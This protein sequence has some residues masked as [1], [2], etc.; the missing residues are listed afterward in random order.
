MEVIL[1]NVSRNGNQIQLNIGFSVLINALKTQGISPRLIDLIPVD[2]DKRDEYLRSQIS[3]EKAIYGFGIIIGNDHIN[4]TEEAAKII[5]KKNPD[6]IIVYGGAL[7]TSAPKVI[8]ENCICD[9]IVA[10]EG[11]YTFPAL[12]RFLDEGGRY[13]E[14]IPGLYYI[15]DGKFHG[16][17]HKKIMSLGPES[18]LDLGQFDM[19]FYIGYLK[20]C[21]Q[22]WEIMAARG[23]VGSCTFCYKMLG[24][25]FS[26]RSPDAVL[27]EMAYIMDRH[28]LGKFYF[29]DDNVFGLNEWFRDF[30]RRK[31]QRRMDFKF[32][33]QA[34]MDAIEEEIC[35]VAM[36]NGLIC[37]ST[38]IE[39]VTQEILDRINKEIKLDDIKKKIRMVDR[40]GIPL[41]TNLIIGFPWET[42]DYYRKMIEFMKDFRLEKRVNMHYLT[43]LPKTVIY[44]QAIKMGLIKDEWDYIRNVGN[45]YWELYLN[46]TKLPDDVLI[47]WF[48]EMLDLAHRDIVFPV[49]EKYQSK[50]GKKYYDRVPQSRR[51][52]QKNA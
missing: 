46:M 18:N 12:V 31:Q 23:C 35:K 47:H 37:I 40:I 30:I 16:S 39:G 24:H 51:I 8:L 32:V 11:E 44:H 2:V 17:S 52:Y 13:P 27:D 45:L 29:V 19:D 38:G 15:K 21:N 42:E 3:S 49:S 1:V 14:N 36:D 28:G 4:A 10:G 9:Y 41:S 26:V 5:R 22:S 7:P 33:I 20:E 6:N 34:R 25:G 48:K 50:L 43:P